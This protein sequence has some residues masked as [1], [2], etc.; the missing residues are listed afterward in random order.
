MKEQGSK[1]C[2]ALCLANKMATGSC[3]ELELLPHFPKDKGFSLATGT[4]TGTGRV[5]FAKSLSI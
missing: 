2:C 1:F 3:K 4:G 5:I